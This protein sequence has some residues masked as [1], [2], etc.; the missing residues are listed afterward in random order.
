MHKP[1]EQLLKKHIREGIKGLDSTI[2]GLE[3]LIK[4]Y[5]Q[6][7][8]I[9]EVLVPI[10]EKADPIYTKAYTK[11]AD[12]IKLFWHS[13]FGE[14]FDAKIKAYRSKYEKETAERLHKKGLPM[15]I[16][17]FLANLIP[18]SEDEKVKENLAYI[19]GGFILGGGPKRWITLA[20]EQ[21]GV[22]EKEINDGEFYWRHWNN[23]KDTAETAGIMMGGKALS[24]IGIDT[25]F[26]FSP[27]TIIAVTAGTCAVRV[28]YYEWRNH[29][30]KKHEKYVPNY[31][32]I[33]S[34]TNIYSSLL[35][36]GGDLVMTLDEK[37]KI[38]HKMHEG[39]KNTVAYLKGTYSSV[40]N[41]IKRTFSSY[42]KADGS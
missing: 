6:T 20:A 13:Y 3:D 36:F 34:P 11:T 24:F 21:S 23:L 5:R 18:S 4:S 42:D 27:E 26:N 2:T 16:S 14:Y 9:D 35:L 8:G 1:M 19:L 15:H 29:L 39:T 28:A 40:K 31:V 38:F 33:A 25:E 12:T 32:K 17:K 10:I 41:G 22:T 30:W 7:T 37:S